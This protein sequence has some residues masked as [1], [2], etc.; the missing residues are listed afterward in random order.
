MNRPSP[1]PPSSRSTVATVEAVEHVTGLVGAHPRAVVP[2]LQDGLGPVHGHADLHRGARR[3]VGQGVADQ[4]VDH[5]LQPGVVARHRHLGRRRAARWAGWRRASWRRPP[6]RRPPRPR[7][8]RCRAGTG[9][10]P[11]RARTARSPTS[12][13][14]R[15]ASLLDAGQGPIPGRV[16]GQG[17]L[18]EQLGVARMEVSGV[19]SSWEASARK[20]RRRSSDTARW[21]NAVSIWASIPLR[22]RPSRAI[23]PSPSWAAP[24]GSGP[25]RR[26][27]RPPWPCPP[28]AGGPG[29]SRRVMRISNATSRP[30]RHRQLDGPQG[31]EGGVHRVETGGHHQRPPGQRGGLEAVLPGPCPPA[32]RP[33]GDGGRAR[34]VGLTGSELRTP[35][36][37]AHRRGRLPGSSGPWI[38]PGLGARGPSHDGAAGGVDAAPR[39]GRGSPWVLM[40]AGV[41]LKPRWSARVTKAAIW[42]A[43]H[44]QLAVDPPVEVGLER[45]QGD[46]V[47]E[48]PDPTATRPIMVTTRRRRSLMAVAPAGCSRPAGRCGSAA[49]RSGRPSC[50]GRRCR[51][52]RCWT[53]RR[54]RRPT[55]RRGSGPWTA[56]G[57]RCATR[58]ASR[59]NSVAV[60]SMGCSPRHTS[61]VP[62]STTRS[63]KRSR[64]SSAASSAPVRRSTARIRATS[65]S[66]LNGLVT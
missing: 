23:S 61:W 35:S 56:P 64:P 10:S 5:L 42:W 57:G 27:R 9:P 16:V 17:V 25:R 24:G 3:G 30:E 20:L 38:G 31:V 15:A 4:V 45:G 50:G 59:L 33:D 53:R 28:G 65:S 62:T 6:P 52:R 11:S 58:K 2:H 12:T 8:T 47:D 32:E 19:R 36:E 43:G 22:A 7:S 1:E 37:R 40:E 26:W 51:S 48:R 41:T 63:P 39:R 29:G 18:A 66:M 14:I 21:A 44:R 60:R 13:P 54:S 34:P 55:P 46:D 49:G